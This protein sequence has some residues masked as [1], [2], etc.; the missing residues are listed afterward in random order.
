MSPLVPFASIWERD[1]RCRGV[2]GLPGNIGDPRCVV[3]DG[4]AS[5]TCQLERIA[6][7]SIIEESR[8]SIAHLRRPW[9]PAPR[10]ELSVRYGVVLLAPKTL[11]AEASRQPGRR[12]SEPWA[13]TN[14]VGVAWSRTPGM[15]C[16]PGPL[17]GLSLSQFQ[18]PCPPGLSTAPEP[19][20]LLTVRMWHRECFV[21]WPHIHSDGPA[22]LVGAQSSSALP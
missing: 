21:L 9:R 16:A 11:H 6:G 14:C 20:D 12:R 19:G 2:S 13:E 7:C 3:L 18:A 1:Y 15:G 8:A 5:Q 22:R 10:A 4:R 17:S